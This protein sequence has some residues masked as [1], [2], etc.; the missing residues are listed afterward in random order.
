MAR[1]LPAE[2]SVKEEQLLRKSRHVRPLQ[3]N[4]I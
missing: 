1:G 4:G 2:E 3:T